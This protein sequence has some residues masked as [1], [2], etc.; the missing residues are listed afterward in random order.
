MRIQILVA[1]MNQT[2]YSLIEKM[3]IKTDAII[4]NQC[5]HNNIEEFECNGQKRNYTTFT[6]YFSKQLIVPFYKFFI[7]FKGFNFWKQRN[8]RIK[9]FFFYIANGNK[10]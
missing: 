1:T 2:D 10:F 6:F 3:N 4:G 9:L 5:N 8:K 7:T